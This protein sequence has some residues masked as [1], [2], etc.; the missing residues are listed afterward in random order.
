[1]RD[2][3]S[4]NWSYK[5]PKDIGV[6]YKCKMLMDA[7]KTPGARVAMIT[8]LALLPTLA[9]LLIKLWLCFDSVHFAAVRVWGF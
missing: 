7:R 5:E 1:M 8:T 2:S 4:G 6:L 3:L 9:R